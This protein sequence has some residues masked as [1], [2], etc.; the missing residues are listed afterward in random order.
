MFL[1]HEDFNKIEGVPLKDIVLE[2]GLIFS[3]G[4]DWAK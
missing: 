2:K 4:E 3:K 1:N